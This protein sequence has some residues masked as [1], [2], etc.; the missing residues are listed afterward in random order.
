MMGVEIIAVLSGA[1]LLLEMAHGDSASALAKFIL[2]P[3]APTPYGDIFEAAETVHMA[4]DLAGNYKGTVDIHGKRQVPIRSLNII[5]D[6]AVKWALS[7]H[8]FPELAKLQMAKMKPR[9]L[10]RMPKRKFSDQ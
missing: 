7:H 6:R 9:Q 3:L 8:D 2:M 1:K 10:G 5:N 4:F